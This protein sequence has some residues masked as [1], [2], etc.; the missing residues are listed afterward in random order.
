MNLLPF[1]QKKKWLIYELLHFLIRHQKRTN[2]FLCLHSNF[3]TIHAHPSLLS[4]PSQCLSFRHK[5]CSILSPFLFFCLRQPMPLSNFQL[6]G[7]FHFPLSSFSYPLLRKR[8][9]CASLLS[10][11]LALVGPLCSLTPSLFKAQFFYFSLLF[12]ARSA[13][14]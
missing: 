3:T 5:R 2:Q 1:S 9:V 13:T 7:L 10:M 11:F 6:E 8:F 12:C 14:S 4:E